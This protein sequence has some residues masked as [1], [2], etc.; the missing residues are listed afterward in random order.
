MWQEEQ[1]KLTQPDSYPVPSPV[2][3]PENK[4]PQPVNPPFVP[5]ALPA[6]ILDRLK[7][8]PILPI[9]II[10]PNVI[11]GYGGYVPPES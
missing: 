4:T 8:V 2:V 9:I 10:D 5:L 6:R 3:V 1:R 7:L 11:D